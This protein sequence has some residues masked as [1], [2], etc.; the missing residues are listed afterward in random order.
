MV[1]GELI[2]A[3][4]DPTIVLEPT[5]HTFDQVAVPVGGRV[6]CP[7]LLA[8]RLARDHGS[9]TAFGEPGAQ[10][11]GVVAQP[12][13]ANKLLDAGSAATSDSAT[14]MSAICAP[15][16]SRTQGRPAVYNRMDLRTAPAA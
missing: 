3:G 1:D 5:E 14:L 6:E 9:C 7:R 2:V 10:P 16:S 8:V 12:L 11:I 4:R 15:V 13:S